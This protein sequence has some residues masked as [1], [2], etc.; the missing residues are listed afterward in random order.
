M[1]NFKNTIFILFLV[2]SFVRAQAAVSTGST[3]A[4]RSSG[5]TD[6]TNLLTPSGNQSTTGATATGSGTETINNNSTTT[7]NPTG[8]NGTGNVSGVGTDMTTGT[9]GVWNNTV[10]STTT[11]APAG[12]TTGT[13][14]TGTA[15][16]NCPAG[17]TTCTDDRTSR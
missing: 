3:G 17:D 14:G 16:T 7:P 5:Y 13:V 6:T 11:E 4:A 15:R 10:P 9:S 1:K 12:S 2:T 8:I